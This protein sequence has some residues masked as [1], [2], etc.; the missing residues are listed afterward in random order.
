MAPRRFTRMSDGWSARRLPAPAVRTSV[1]LTGAPAAREPS[2]RRFNQVTLNPERR[3]HN[4]LINSGAIVCCALIRPHDSPADRFDFM[5]RR[6]SRFAGDRRVGFDN[7]T[8]LSERTTADRNFALAYYMR[9]HGAFPAG[10]DLHDVL[11]FY[12]QLCSVAMTAETLAVV[13]GTLANGGNCPI[14]GEQVMS[15]EAVRSAL[16]LMYSCGMYDYSGEF[17]FTVGLPAKSGVSGGLMIVV[18]NIMVGA[19]AYPAPRCA[20]RD[21][22][23]LSGRTPASPGNL[24]V[25]AA[26]R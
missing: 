20:R 26:A 15:P 1:T 19:P 10:A 13:A 21:L 4:P 11:E 8:Y 9:E 14:T 22:T 23:C 16:S 25:V 5:T 12:F 24:R 2:G 17:A 3:P 6:Y 7:A 18:P